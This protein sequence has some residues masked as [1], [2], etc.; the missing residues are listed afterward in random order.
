MQHP[1]NAQNAGFE[2]N[3]AKFLT[4][5]ELLWWCTRLVE[6]KYNKL[7]E[8]MEDVA[9]YSAAEWF[10]TLRKLH[11]VAFM[12]ALPCDEHNMHILTTYTCAVLNG[13][14]TAQDACR[15]HHGPR[16]AE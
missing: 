5:D 10:Q 15:G 7:E 12:N 9:V 4:A 8:I 13:Y 14:T 11:P 1:Q 2:T 6:H 16:I 3:E